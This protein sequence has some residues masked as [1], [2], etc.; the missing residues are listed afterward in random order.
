MIDIQ[1]EHSDYIIYVDE[2]GDHSLESI[3]P[4]YPLFVLAFCVFQK[5]HYIQKVLPALS[6][7]KF[8]TFGHDLIILHEQEIR[9]RTGVFN[10]LN[11]PRRENLLSALSNLMAEINVTL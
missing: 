11:F 4:R 1:P 10:H 5:N 9:K 2:S 8:S 6:E 7:L 3:N